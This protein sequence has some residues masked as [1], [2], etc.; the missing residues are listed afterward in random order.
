MRTRLELRE[1]LKQEI[2]LEQLYFQPPSSVQMKY[3]CV[4]YKHNNFYIRHSDNYPYIGYKAYQIIIIDKDPDSV[5]QDRP[6]RIPMCRFDRH[7]TSDNLHH[8]VYTLYF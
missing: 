4:V 1:I 3:P 7:Y 2:G 6:L 8:W 5:Y